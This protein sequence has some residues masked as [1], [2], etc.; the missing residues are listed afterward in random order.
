MGTSSSCLPLQNRLWDRGVTA[1]ENSTSSYA[2]APAP[3]VAPGFAIELTN[4]NPE[5]P[6]NYNTEVMR[7]PQIKTCFGEQLQVGVPA[8]TTTI[9][10]HY[11]TITSNSR[12]PRGSSHQA[13]REHQCTKSFRAPIRPLPSAKAHMM[14]RLSHNAYL[15]VQVQ[16][17]LPD[18]I[19]PHSKPF[20]SN[21]TVKQA[22]V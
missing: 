5:A 12:P 6:E 4:N 18:S 8:Y 20:R 7:T 13:Y 10:S 22:N 16:P 11:I 2:V 1:R 15:L 14:Q 19:E 17:V 3:A 21:V 9:D